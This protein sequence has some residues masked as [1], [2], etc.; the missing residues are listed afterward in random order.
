VR[1]LV[2]ANVAAWIVEYHLDGLRIDAVQAMHDDSPEPIVAAIARVAREAAGR[3]RVLVIGEDEPQDAALVR[4]RERGGLALDALWNDDF[5]HAARV[6]ASGRAE[7]YLSPY[8]GSAQELLSATKWGF[9]Y[10]GQLYPW[11][12]KR[13]GTAALDVD[14][15][16]LI[17]YLDNH[18]QV[19]NN[20]R[21]LRLH[22]R[23]SP[24]RWR[25]LTTLLLLAPQ[26]PL[27][28]QGQEMA[29]SAPFLY[30][31]D[32]PGEVA[33]GVRDGRR[34]FLGQFPS[35]RGEDAAGM[36]ADP[37]DP[38]T[39]AACKLDWDDW[40]RHAEAVALH[41]DL[42]RLRRDDP[43]FARPRR[44]VDGAVLGDSA[45][46]LRWFGEDGDDRLLLVNLGVL[47]RLPAAPEP[48]LGPAR[49]AAWQI[50]WSS[51]AFDYGGCGTP[52]TLDDDLEGWT[53][54]G[55]AAV[56]LAP[57]SSPSPEEGQP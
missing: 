31:A 9:L 49:G 21:G 2:L 33:Q 57:A 13:R 55:E 43:T 23:T 51:E 17:I 48:L 46:V 8:R 1:E 15:R 20:A 41:R 47:L 5:H 30:F 35:L 56:A 6:A 34:A 54:P 40:E 18:D 28:F 26:T 7:A 10:Q 52:A 45:F 50:V 22:R 39:F 27:L 11:Q 4:P 25:A 3:R 12:R 29:A 38:A 24:G 36:L 32:H 42:L 37:A 16:R 14:P 19:A 53:I 44:R